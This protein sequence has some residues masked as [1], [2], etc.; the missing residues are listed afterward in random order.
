MGWRAGGWA[1]LADRLIREAGM[2]IGVLNV[3]RLLALQCGELVLQTR[4]LGG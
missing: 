2:I 4:K 1:S 3:A